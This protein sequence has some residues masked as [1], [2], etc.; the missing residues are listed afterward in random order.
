MGYANSRFMA[1][2]IF[3]VVFFGSKNSHANI[4]AHI[5]LQKKT[6]KERTQITTTTFTTKQI[7]FWLNFSFLIASVGIFDFLFVLGWHNNKYES[8]DITQIQRA[9]RNL[10]FCFTFSKKRGVLNC[11]SMKNISFKEVVFCWWNNSCLCAEESNFRDRICN[12]CICLQ[13]FWM[14]DEICATSAINSNYW[15][16]ILPLDSLHWPVVFIVHG[17]KTLN[18]AVPFVQYQLKL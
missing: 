12:F 15:L 9:N 6:S 17:P 1:I 11:V 13:L 3:Q 16:A 4:Y 7:S 18:N 2:P 8:N 10:C 5:L 14:K